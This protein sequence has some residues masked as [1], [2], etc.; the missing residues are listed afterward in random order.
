[1][2]PLFIAML[3]ILMFPFFMFD[4]LN[5]HLVEVGD[6]SF[7]INNRGVD[8]HASGYVRTPFTHYFP[9]GL[10]SFNKLMSTMFALLFW[11]MLY[12][13]G[14]INRRIKQAELDYLQLQNNLKDAQLLGL[15]NQ[16]NPHFLFNS[17]NNIRFMIHENQQ[18]ADDLVVSLAEI[19]RYSLV[20]GQQE[21]ISLDE[22]LAIVQQYIEIVSL[23]LESRLDFR[24]KVSLTNT[25]V[26]VPPML[27]QLLI[28]NAIKHGID[29]IKHQSQLNLDISQVAQQVVIKVNNPIAKIL[30]ETTGTGIGLANIKQRLLL[31]YGDRATLV[32]AHKAATFYATITLPY[33]QI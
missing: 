28:E 23:Q 16:L 24:L 27:I 22:E 1:M 3:S 15:S 20:R 18:K 2:T 30:N 5:T 8:V 6:V 25:Q 7:N 10:F 21:K 31:L 12:S 19:L 17:L 32:T 26:L 11:L 33:E 9:L 13:A 4:M 14:S 29:N